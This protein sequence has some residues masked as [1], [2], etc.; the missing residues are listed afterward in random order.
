MVGD[1]ETGS[2]DCTPAMPASFSRLMVASLP[3]EKTTSI[4]TSAVASERAS[5]ERTERRAAAQCTEPLSTA[6]V[7]TW[8]VSYE[9]A[10]P[11]M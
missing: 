6:S 11:D 8:T 9:E 2:M 10:A 5:S 4:V 7:V 1:M 3:L